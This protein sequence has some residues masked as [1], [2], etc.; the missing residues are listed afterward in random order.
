MRVRDL[1]V[2]LLDNCGS[3]DD[4]VSIYVSAKTETVEECI[5]LAE[6]SEWALDEILQIDEIEDRGGHIW[7]KAEEICI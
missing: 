6:G 4:S 1:I 3:L 7:L 5:K 2:E